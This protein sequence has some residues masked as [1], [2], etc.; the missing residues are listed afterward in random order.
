MRPREEPALSIGYDTGP[1]RRAERDLF[2]FSPFA[3][4]SVERPDARP[5]AIVQAA[6]TQ[7]VER[8][9]G[10]ICGDP[11]I[12]GEPIGTIDGPG[13]CGVEGAVKVRSIA[14]VNLQTNPTVDCR[15]A[16]AMKTWITNGIIP[17]VGGT[18]GGVARLRV[19]GHYVCRNRVGGS[20]GNRRL[21][22]HALGHAVD[23][24]GIGLKSGREI[25][26]L[27]DWNSR[28]DGAIL[29]RVWQSACGPFGTVLGPNANAAH[30]D[31]FHVDTAR[32]RS[33]AYCR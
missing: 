22:E 21:S 24:A 13:G 23:I 33:G 17:A 8:Q 19:V 11:E 26:V 30:R 3:P 25:T 20:S 5:A 1:Q 32:Y 14:G 4:R 31:H 29:R 6:I 18:G 16:Q 10:A 7:A 9:R 15:T 2:A 27:T 12:Q 28:S